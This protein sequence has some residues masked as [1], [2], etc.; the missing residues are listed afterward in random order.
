MLGVCCVVLCHLSCLAQQAVA[1]DHS[2]V[3]HTILYDD[4]DVQDA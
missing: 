1:Y 2:N 4:G 3:Q